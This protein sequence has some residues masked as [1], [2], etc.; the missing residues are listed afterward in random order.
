MTRSTEVVEVKRPLRRMALASIVVLAALAVAVSLWKGCRGND[1]AESLSFQHGRANQRGWREDFF[2]FSIDNLNRLEE[3]DESMQ[4]RVVGRLNEWMPLVDPI[5]WTQDPMVEQL[6]EEQR[7]LPSIVALADD[8]FT[9]YDGDFLREVVWLRDAAASARIDP[10]LRASLPPPR[11]GERQKDAENSMQANAMRLFDWT[12]RNIALETADSDE[13]RPPKFLSPWQVMLRGRGTAIARAWVFLLLARQRG[14]DIVMLAYRDPD[15]AGKWHDWAPALFVDQK[16]NASEEAA[17]WFVFEP[18]LGIAIPGPEG[19]PIAT[20]TELREDEQL[21]RRLDLD[22]NHTYPV[23]ANQLEHVAAWIE[24]SPGYLS[25][26]ERQLEYS[27]SGKQKMVLHV[28]A[29]ALARR[30]QET[31]QF[32]TVG[33]WKM[34]YEV[35]A[36]RDEEEIHRFAATWFPGSGA[37]QMP[38]KYRPWVRSVRMGR[39]LHLKGKYSGTLGALHEYQEARPSD[40]EINDL[41]DKGKTAKLPTNATEDAKDERTWLTEAEVQRVRRAKHDASFWLGTV[42]FERGDYNT[43]IDYF[44]RRTL[45]AWPNGPWANAARYNLARTFEALGRNEEAIEIY[46]ND[47]SPQQHG[48]RLRARWLQEKVAAGTTGK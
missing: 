13:E 47:D 4:G 34:P 27:L 28:D 24:A 5:P 3:Y 44:Q 42:A 37:E 15:E 38:S 20:L 23:T 45:E 26:R 8:R 46:E 35:L 40:S 19:R 22:A 43:A 10:A 30:L 9:A 33:P 31:G 25:R 32:D 48:N 14:L 7:R 36:L 2:E 41:L 1:P 21:L 29:S 12:I 17:K 39:V 6:S 11:Q 18:E 16:K